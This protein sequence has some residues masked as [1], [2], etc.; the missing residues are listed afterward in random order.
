MLKAPAAQLTIKYFSLCTLCLCGE[1]FFE[2]VFYFGAHGAPYKKLKTAN[3]K[4]KTAN[5]K[6]IFLYLLNLSNKVNKHALTIIIQIRQVIRE[7]GE[8]ITHTYF[9]IV[10]DMPVQP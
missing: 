5:L 10:A 8:V 2:L 1:I 3:L 7:I 9:Y 6:L 4:L